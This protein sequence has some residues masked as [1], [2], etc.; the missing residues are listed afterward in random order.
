M[1]MKIFL[2]ISVE[3]DVTDQL[4]VIIL[5]FCEIIQKNLNNVRQFISCLSTSRKP[6]IRLGWSFLMLIVRVL[7]L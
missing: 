4:L 1:Q 3:F 7:S 2:V 6:V 5:C